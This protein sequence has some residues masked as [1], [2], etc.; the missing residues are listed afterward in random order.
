MSSIL[1]LDFIYL[2]WKE[3][4]N[5]HWVESLSWRSFTIL[6]ILGAVYLEECRIERM[7]PVFLIVHGSVY[8]LRYT[9]TT[10]L[11]VGSR[12]D[13]EIDSEK[14]TDT[15]RFFNVFLFFVDLFL[16]VWFII[17]SV[18]IYAN[19]SDVQY[20]DKN[21]SSYCSRVAYLLAFWFAT[22]H[23]IALG[24]CMLCCPCILC[25]FYAA[26][27]YWMN[28]IKYMMDVRLR[29]RVGIHYKGIDNKIGNVKEIKLLSFHTDLQTSGFTTYS[30]LSHWNE[31][32][33][34]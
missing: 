33:H 34:P 5:A 27:P 10:C 30:G 32:I 13:N 12:N 29:I 11:R 26:V 31:L 25:Y 18:W 20:H 23:Y 22:V 8:L 15:I 21:A 1:A 6:V 16:V 19:F 7:I 28:A 14:D 4:V 2:L 24:M 3:F 17:G 9:I